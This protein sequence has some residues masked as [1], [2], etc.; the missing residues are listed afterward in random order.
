MDAHEIPD[1][2]QWHEGL[3]LTPQHFQQLTL[4]QETLLQYVAK[5]VTPFYWGVSK[6]K[7]DP[8]SLVSGTFRVL[9]L[10]AVMPDSLVVSSGLRGDVELSVD[11]NPFKTQ[12]AERPVP[13]HLAVPA[14]ETD[15]LTKGDLPR[16]KSSE[17]RPVFNDE[18]NEQVLIPRLRPR[19]SL[20]VIDRPSRKFVSFPLARVEYKDE[21]FVLTDYIPPRLSVTP[22]SELGGMCLFAAK[23][24][25]EK[26]I[27]LA[28]HLR[29][30]AGSA[31]A[32][33][34]LKNETLLRSLVAPLP[35]LE[36]MLNAGASHPYQ[37]YLALCNVLGHLS[38]M[39]WSPLPPQLAAYDHD[40]LRAA[41]EEVLSHIATK[42]RQGISPSFTAHPFKYSEGIYS[43]EF[44]GEWAGKRL[45]IGIRGQSGMS[46]AEIVKWGRECLIVSRRKF[47]ELRENRMTG[48]RRELIE[49]DGD[50]VPPRGVVLFSL[51]PD[52]EYVEPDEVLR[53]FN[54]S[55]RPGSPRPSEITLY[56]RSGQSRAKV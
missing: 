32:G 7:I 18:T 22:Q 24:L 40:D 25:R 43:I 4:R 15:S 47:R 52:P 50:L 17:G 33:A 31:G 49:R 36:A 44:E 34:D 29:G 48:A 6:L 27:L 12:M 46:E 2:I 42:I 23:R 28:D 30:P 20:E 26:A 3:L 14:R 10:E 38:V 19:L 11:L 53:I 8:S 54:G 9:E 39:G 1:P 13:V 21:A 37:V 41:F 45:A 56:V 51:N 55:E 16:F 5:T 35:M